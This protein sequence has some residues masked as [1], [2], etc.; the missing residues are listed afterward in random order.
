MQ[1]KQCTRAGEHREAGGEFLHAGFLVVL[2][3]ALFSILF[4]WMGI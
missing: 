1:R 3:D 4:T 2:A